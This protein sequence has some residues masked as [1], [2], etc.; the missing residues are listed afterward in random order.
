MLS[1]LNSC[2]VLWSEIHKINFFPWKIMGKNN[3]EKLPKAAFL[4]HWCHL[5]AMQQG[6]L[7]CY[8]SN[9]GNVDSVEVEKLC[10][11]IIWTIVLF[12]PSLQ[13][14]VSSSH[15]S[16]YFLWYIPSHEILLHLPFS[17]GNLQPKWNTG[18]HSSLTSTALISSE[19]Q[20]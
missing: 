13:S 7:T 3:G 12:W 11:Q 5:T 16:W 17:T 14:S 19:W 15:E 18:C 6:G 2:K 4:K 20:G 10:A 8:F 1:E 9:E